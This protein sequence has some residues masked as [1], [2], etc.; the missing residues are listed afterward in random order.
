MISVKRREAVKCSS[1]TQL[2]LG[3]DLSTKRTRKREFLDEMRRVVPWSKLIALIEPHYPAGKTGRPPFP[4]GT[5]LQI[6]F[7]QQLYGRLPFGKGRHR[8]CQT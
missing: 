5:M 3:L 1:M 7:M 6:H 2:G 4:I 8:C